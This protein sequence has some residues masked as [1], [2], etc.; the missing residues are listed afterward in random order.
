MKK[1]WLSLSLLICSILLTGCFDKVENEVID[2]CIFPEDCA[3]D[4]PSEYL[5]DKY[6]SAFWTEPFWD[7]EISWWIA[8]L[9]S[10]MFDTEY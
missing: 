9:S 10:P 6:L 4:K 8:K 1:I 5:S 7:I 3:V 2:D